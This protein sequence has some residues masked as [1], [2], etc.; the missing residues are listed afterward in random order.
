MKIGEKAILKC[1][2]DYAYGDSPPVRSRGLQFSQLVVD[3]V[4]P[5]ELCRWFRRN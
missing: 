4:H 5:N 3:P 1:R 2:A